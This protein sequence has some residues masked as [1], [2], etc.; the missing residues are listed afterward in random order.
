MIRVAVAV[1]LEGTSTSPTP[2]QAASTPRTLHRAPPRV[3]ANIRRGGAKANI[4]GEVHP[5]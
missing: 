1:S 4:R 5:H 3:Q 2:P